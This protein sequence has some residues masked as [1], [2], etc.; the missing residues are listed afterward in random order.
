MNNNENLHLKNHI[1]GIKKV[2]QI[3]IYALSPILLFGNND[4]D[5]LLKVLDKT[6]D[7]Y[8]IYSNQKERKL[9]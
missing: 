3:F 6:V 9:N 8:Q 4:M 5:S 7:N 2:L 1:T